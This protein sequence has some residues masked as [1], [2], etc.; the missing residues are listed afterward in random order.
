MA[1]GARLESVYTRKGI[2][3]SNPCLSA[4]NT[5]S[6][7]DKIQPKAQKPPQIVPAFSLALLNKSSL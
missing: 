4:S 2:Q 1:E 5:P 7:K 6:N 3:G